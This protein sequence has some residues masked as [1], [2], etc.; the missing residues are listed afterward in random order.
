MGR[1]KEK[2]KRGD[3]GLISEPV[4]STRF[5]IGILEKKISYRIRARCVLLRFEPGAKTSISDIK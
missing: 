3:S 5:A 4:A 1:G 2:G